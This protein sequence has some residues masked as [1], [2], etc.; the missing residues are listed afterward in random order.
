MKYADLLNAGDTIGII[1][2]SHVAAE[3]D[4]R[5][6]VKT[7]ESI[8]FRVKLGA[9]IFKDA[10]GYSA[11]EL[12]RAGDLNDMVSD[13]GVKMILFGG[14]RGASEILPLIDYENIR[15]HPKIFSSYSDGTSILNAVYSKTGL[16]AYYG[17][18][19]GEFRDLR[20]Y[21]Y[22]QF[23]AHFTEGN[24]PDA[25]RG[26]GGWRVICPGVCE[27]VLIG[28]Y[29]Q[30]FALH[31][32]GE[33]FCYDPRRKYILFLEDHEKFSSPAAVSVYL[34]HI[35]QHD[36]ICRVGGLI[37]GHYSDSAPDDLLRRLERFGGKH[38]I[39]VVYCDDFGHYTK[40][41][42]LPIG[43]SAR[44]DTERQALIFERRE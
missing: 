14:G 10:Y 23:S 17:L 22:A 11:S 16:V 40:H 38:D 32:G 31:L 9:N 4:Y 28:G 33:Y 12:E 34:S 39:P 19:A 25:L 24:N 8:G 20:Y 18:G 27:G 36:F 43:V 3:A 1:S 44:L 35:E 2:P 37:F 41:S 29:T 13:S 21:D 30:N 5:Q 15:R 42:I 6:I 26:D 7:I